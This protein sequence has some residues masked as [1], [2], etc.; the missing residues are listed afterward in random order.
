MFSE[1]CPGREKRETAKLSDA[2][3]IVSG[4]KVLIE[5]QKRQQS[6]AKKVLLPGARDDTSRPCCRH[7]QRWVASAKVVVVGLLCLWCVVNWYITYVI[8]AISIRYICHGAS[9]HRYPIHK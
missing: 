7:W 5:E 3:F 6:N 9:Q 8:L 4:S 1:K 2:T